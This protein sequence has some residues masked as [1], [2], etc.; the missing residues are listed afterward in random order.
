MDNISEATRTL[1]HAEIVRACDDAIKETILSDKD[2]VSKK[3]LLDM[4]NERHSAYKKL[5]E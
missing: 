4:L 2:K 3:Q 5:E 1:S